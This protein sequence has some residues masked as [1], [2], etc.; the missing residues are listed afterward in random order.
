VVTLPTSTAP[1]TVVAA[2]LFLGDSTA[3]QGASG[4][5]HDDAWYRMW[6]NRE[7]TAFRPGRLYAL[8]MQVGHDE[9]TVDARVSVSLLAGITPIN[10]QTKV[11]VSDDVPTQNL[12][13]VFRAPLQTTELPDGEISEYIYSPAISISRADTDGGDVTLSDI[14]VVELDGLSAGWMFRT[15]G[16]ETV[17]AF[18]SDV[19]T[20][21]L[22]DS[23]GALTGCTA[24]GCLPYT[25]EVT[26]VSIAWW[27][28]DDC[29]SGDAA[30]TAAPVTLGTQ[31]VKYFERFA[32]EGPATL[33]ADHIT[34]ITLPDLDEPIARMKFLPRYLVSFPSLA[35]TEI[36]FASTNFAK[37]ATWL[38]FF[39]LKRNPIPFRSVRTILSL[40]AIIAVKSIS[41]LS[42]F[43]RPKAS[44]CFVL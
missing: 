18:G 38:M 8:H 24:A 21:Y 44:A 15:E 3:G 1:H 7:A 29:H 5:E 37:P 28:E 4:D 11:T 30:G 36:V 17:P 12:S 34:R 16:V 32:N 40:R 14:T 13:F 25:Q 23:E 41:A 26:S 43:L 22:V 35:V 39:F 6:S 9:G 19:P 27:E 31:G 2:T 20:G 33:T 10:L 42:I